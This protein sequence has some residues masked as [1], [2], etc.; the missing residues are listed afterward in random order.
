MSQKKQSPFNFT[1]LFW[2]K[3]NQELKTKY[4]P[5]VALHSFWY[6]HDNAMEIFSFKSE[7][8]ICSKLIKDMALKMYKNCFLLSLQGITWY[9]ALPFT[10]A[11]TVKSLSR[12]HGAIQFIVYT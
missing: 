2:N 9:V 8:K 4:I 11:I 3:K 1:E 7:N 12:T 10:D 5:K 6:L